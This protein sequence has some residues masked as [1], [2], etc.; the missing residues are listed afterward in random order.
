MGVVQLAARLVVQ[1][2]QRPIFAL[3]VG[4]QCLRRSRGTSAPRRCTP[5]SAGALCSTGFW[6]RRCDR[7][8]LGSSS[9][10]KTASLTLHSFCR[11]LRAAASRACAALLAS[12]RRC[13]ASF[14][15]TLVALSSAAPAQSA[16]AGGTT[17][18]TL[19]LSVN[20]GAAQMTWTTAARLR[21]SALVASASLRND[22]APVT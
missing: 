20:C 2:L 3:I 13:S 14:R 22:A 21:P 16:T 11:C 1:A 19:P 5:G 9:T 12:L 6:R 7:Q 4:K 18:A 15:S 8:C 17:S 10:S